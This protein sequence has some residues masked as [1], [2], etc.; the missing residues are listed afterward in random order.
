[1]LNANPRATELIVRIRAPS[2]EQVPHDD[3]LEG[4]RTWCHAK[5]Q[6]NLEQVR[7]SRKFGVRMLFYCTGLLALMLVAS[8]ALLNEDLFGPAGP[9]RTLA[10]E[11]IVIAGWVA[12]WRPFEMVL[13]DPLRPRYESRLLEHLLRL[14]WHMQDA[15]S[16][17]STAP[18][19]ATTEQEAEN[20]K[21]VV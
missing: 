12:M 9:I 16:A 15:V 17:R 2:N 11:A 20:T 8:W 10:S 14:R 19:S 13:F 18:V 4:L 7:L 3:I 5:I 1:M 6:I 21:H